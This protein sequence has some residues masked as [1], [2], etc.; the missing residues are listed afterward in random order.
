MDKLSKVLKVLM[1]EMP[2]EPFLNNEVDCMAV[3]LELLKRA[4]RSILSGQGET[5]ISILLKSLADSLGKHADFFGEN[6]HIKQGS[7][8]VF[9]AIF[10]FVDAMLVKQNNEVLCRYEYLLRWRS[11]TISIGEELFVTAFLAKLDMEEGTMRNSF[12]WKPVISH[13]NNQLKEI[14]RRGL[15]ENHFHLWGSAPYFQL[16][17]ICMMNEVTSEQYCRWSD[18]IDDDARIYYYQLDKSY[19]K[20]SIQN[21]YRMAAVIRLLL[22]SHITNMQ[23]EIC[24]YFIAKE[25]L[26][27]WIL[28]VDCSVSFSSFERII[29]LHYNRSGAFILREVFN[30]IKSECPEKYSRIKESEPDIDLLFD[31]RIDWM[32]FIEKS[33][34][35]DKIF[36]KDIF[37]YMLKDRKQIRLRYCRSMIR[38][39]EYLNLWWNAT[40]QQVFYFACNPDALERHAD[41][42]QNVIDSLGSYVSGR[43]EDYAMSTSNRGTGEYS[44][45]SVLSGERYVLYEM[46]RSVLRYDK[47]TVPH[48]YNLFYVYLILK[49]KIRGELVQSNSWI[50]FE[51]FEKYQ[52]RKDFFA[53]GIE[54]DRIKAK[55]AV[56][57][58]REQN[59][60]LLEIRI[61]L[62]STV[63]EFNKKIDFLDN[64]IDFT[65][66]FR[67]EFFYVVHFI[68][69]QDTYSPTECYCA[70][71]HAKLRASIQQ[72]AQ[73]LIDFRHECPLR[74]QRI[75]GID[76][77]S[78]EIGC[79]PEVFAQVFRALKQ[80]VSRYHTIEGEKKLPQLYATYHVGE[81]FLD[82]ADGLR[83]IDEAIL[84]LNLDCGDRLGHAL[85]L[86]VC[87]RDW[88]QLKNSHIAICKQ[89]YLD[90]IV[91]LYHSLIRYCIDGFENLKNKIEEKYQ[92]YFAD[93]YGNH[94]TREYLESVMSALQ[95][96]T[97]GRKDGE[98]SSHAQ[99]VTRGYLNFDIYS[100]YDAWKLRGDNPELY[101]R[102]Y[103][104]K[105]ESFITPFDIHAV[106]YNFP[107]EYDVRMR[108]EAAIIYHYYHYNRE[109]RLEG[110]KEIDFKVTSDYIQAIES[111]QHAMQ[112]ELVKRGIAIETNPSSN[113]L[114][115]TFRRYEAHPITAFYNNRLTHDREKLEESAQIWTSINT[116]D[117]GVFG[118]TLENEYALMARALEKKTD[119]D[120]NYVYQ[121]SMIYD[122]LEK[123]REMGFSQSF[124]NGHKIN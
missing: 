86:G 44:I 72:K 47:K 120:G 102:G 59:V 36:L 49:E 110:K 95:K 71:R 48:I 26:S 109:V 34:S 2:Y 33:K 65:N 113:C 67:D 107:A 98:F 52:S 111:V 55:M 74:A 63:S 16:A 94:I 6:S 105:K 103:F 11:T 9:E 38:E 20:S 41:Q 17:W 116:D 93:I 112:V 13:N 121:K 8:S 28:E 30:V 7:F 68:K 43:L 75:L 119:E 91:W 82:I 31:R 89:D 39:K 14:T 118:C 115:G 15:A 27:V 88:Y 45:Y 21:Y 80:D 83:A 124:S 100:Y 57:S 46:F 104:R 76:A 23:I 35:N 69:K 24:P 66:N 101:A 108:P 1:R 18:D 40:Y 64:A 117:Q 51:N 53:R 90:N 58:C 50:G 81:D 4:V 3:D 84:F 5:E 99:R 123:I 32:S 78:Q 25:W 73:A 10:R 29:S 87:V 22:F 37:E 106:N 60:C 77:A 97:E 85:A 79:R 62:G 122:W 12:V 54:Y 96:W 42:I 19:S 114:I 56:Y 92:K 61:T 70:V